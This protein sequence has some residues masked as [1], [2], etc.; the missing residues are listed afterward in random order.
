MFDD[1]D[2][3]CWNIDERKL[4]ILNRFSNRVF[5]KV[6]GFPMM[7]VRKHTKGNKGFKECLFILSCSTK[8]STARSSYE[9]SIKSFMT[10]VNNMTDEELQFFVSGV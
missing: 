10:T 7:S 9:K 6:L 8:A 1:R 3:L 4:S 2:I 5:T